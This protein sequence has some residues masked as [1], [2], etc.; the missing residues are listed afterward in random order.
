M[1]FPHKALLNTLRRARFVFIVISTRNLYEP[2]A[3]SRNTLPKRDVI[4]DK[5]ESKDLR[6]DDPFDG[7]KDCSIE[8]NFAS[9]KES[10]GCNIL[11]ILSRFSKKRWIEILV[12]Y[13][14]I[15]QKVFTNLGTSIMVTSPVFVRRPIEAHKYCPKSSHWNNTIRHCLTV[16]CETRRC[17][18]V[19]SPPTS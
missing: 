7:L 19:L 9:D 18:R 3:T 17:L 8:R 5:K 11:Y 6:S 2:C 10:S 12:R 14:K 15:R 13:V 4:L 1:S 16:Y